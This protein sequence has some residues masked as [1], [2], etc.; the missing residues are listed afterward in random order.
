MFRSFRGVLAQFG[1]ACLLL[2]GGS[3]LVKLIRAAGGPPLPDPAATFVFGGG[4]IALGYCGLRYV[5]LEYRGGIASVLGAFLAFLGAFSFA[6]LV[7]EPESDTTFVVVNVAMGLLLTAAGV[8]LLRRGHRRHLRPVSGETRPAQSPGEPTSIGIRTMCAA[9]AAAV[10]ALLFF[11][12][13]KD[14]EPWVLVIFTTSMFLVFWVGF[15]KI[16]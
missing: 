7:G 10:V 12:F 15:S 6:V 5:Q 16:R 8:A 1:S 14:M 4:M 3:A 13:A 9:I 2:A 11:T